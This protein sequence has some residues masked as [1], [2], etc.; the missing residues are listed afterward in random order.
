[1]A[2]LKQENQIWHPHIVPA[3]DALIGAPDMLMPEKQTKRKADTL[4]IPEI[5]IDK[6]EAF[7]DELSSRGE[8]SKNI[9]GYFTDILG[10]IHNSSEMKDGFICDNGMIIKFMSPEDVNLSSSNQAKSSSAFTLATAKTIQ[11]SYGVNNTA[12][13]TGD[14]YMS[15]KAYRKNIDVVH[16]N[17]EVYTG[18]R[19]L[20]LP[21]DL[22]DS[23]FKHRS[24]STEQFSSY[25]PN[26]AKLKSNEYVQFEVDHSYACT[27]G[28]HP[29][30]P[31][32]LIG[33]FES[34]T[35]RLERI[36]YIENVPRAIQPR[37]PGQAMF[38]E[39]LLAPVEEMPIVVCPAIFGTGKTFLATAL[40]YNYVSSRDPAFDRIFV[41]PRD[42]SLGKD[43]G[44]LPG[45]EQ[46]KTIA[47][48]API[49]D[50]LYNYFKLLNRTS[51]SRY[52][53]KQN[54]RNKVNKGKKGKNVQPADD[55]RDM[56]ES[57]PQYIN[58][59]VN[60]AL[61][62]YFEFVPIVNIGGRSISDSWIIYDEAQDM[63][64]FQIDQLMQRIGDGSKMVIIGDPDQVYNRHMNR[65]SNGLTYAATHLA[66]SPYA[67]VIEMT[68]SE[69]TR[70]VAAREIARCFKR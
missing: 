62:R 26:E 34:G 30:N 14:D 41:V 59:L 24:I 11:D 65:R 12:I 42:S 37:T 27:Y 39:A 69:I 25:F 55:Q 2:A 43:I 51:Q 57:Y 50:S 28:V 33:R 54:M 64:R 47:K 48:A 29:R 52:A 70:S 4:Y 63:E 36:H 6:V 19:K 60:L 10:A 67:A 38:M 58:R 18:R 3:L 5:Y 32:P 16:I 46:Q 13:L 23:W 35:E 44:F 21:A 15:S 9:L 61:E 40:G 56:S 22:Y 8:A 66:N 49:K 53:Q 31:I 7:R 20:V 45:D 68:E 17:P 1:M